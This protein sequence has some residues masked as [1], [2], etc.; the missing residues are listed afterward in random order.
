MDVRI[1]MIYQVAIILLTSGLLAVS[2]WGNV[3]LRYLNK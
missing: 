3:C 2:A 1:G